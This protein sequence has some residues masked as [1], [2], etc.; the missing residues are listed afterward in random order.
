MQLFENGSYDI[1]DAYLRRLY[2]HIAHWLDVA[3][4]EILSVQYIEAEGFLPS[5]FCLKT[6]ALFTIFLLCV[7]QNVGECVL[8]SAKFLQDL[9]YVC[10]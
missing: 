10:G 3:C 4:S 9:P 1:V 2:R 8:I 6:L 5:L 7:Q